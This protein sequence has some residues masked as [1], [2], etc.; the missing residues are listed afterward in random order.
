MTALKEE[1]SPADAL[2]RLEWRCVCVFAR[3]IDVIGVLTTIVKL[4][5]TCNS[6]MYDYDIS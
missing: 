6:T 5:Q 3:L 4:V 1:P 2:Q